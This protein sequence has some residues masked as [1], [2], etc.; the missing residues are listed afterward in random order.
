MLIFNVDDVG[1][2]TLDCLYRSSLKHIT[3][4]DK[5][6]FDTTNQNRQIC[7]KR[8]NEP[9]V[10]VLAQMYPSITP[11]QEQ[12]DS[13]FLK[14]FNI[15]AFGYI[16]DAID[17]IYG[18]VD[19]TRTTL[20]KLLEKFIVSTGSAKKLNPLHIRLDNIWKTHGDK[21]AR[22]LLEYLKKAGIRRSFKAAFS[23]EVPK[24]KAL[25]SCICC[26]NEFWTIALVSNHTKYKIS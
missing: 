4:I 26:N 8:L 12:I 9:K 17:D 5:N 21:F 16:V 6:C 18:K 23:P 13:V 11:M 3:I 15:I 19:I 22:K 2:F 24:C 25:W 1:G 7:T 20:H 14:R 10:A